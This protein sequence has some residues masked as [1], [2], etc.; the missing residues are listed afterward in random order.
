MIETALLTISYGEKTP[1]HVKIPRDTPPLTRSPG[2]SRRAAA[3]DVSLHRCMPPNRLHCLHCKPLHCN[4]MQ[5]NRLHCMQRCNETWSVSERFCV[6]GALTLVSPRCYGNYPR[7]GRGTFSEQPFLGED[8]G[9]FGPPRSN[10]HRQVAEW[11][12][13]WSI[14]LNSLSGIDL[15][16]EAESATCEV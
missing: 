8:G 4:A 11:R 3:H 9:Q 1:T 12:T 10:R 16:R 7:E 13:R 14:N 6:G 2:L 5:R 15:C